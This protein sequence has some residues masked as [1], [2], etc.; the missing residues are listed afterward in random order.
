MT[1]TDIY[2]KEIEITHFEDAK[3]QLKMYAEWE[4][5]D[6]FTLDHKRGYH[7]TPVHPLNRFNSPRL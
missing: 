7:Q 2:G 1:L 3:E 4:K 5:T 6:S